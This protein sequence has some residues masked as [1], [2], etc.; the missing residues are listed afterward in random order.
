LRQSRDLSDQLNVLQ[1]R[2]TKAIEAEDFERAAILRDEI[3]QVTAQ[4]TNPITK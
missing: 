2:L 4:P 1:K 3:K